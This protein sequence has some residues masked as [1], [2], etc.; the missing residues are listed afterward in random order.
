[1]TITGHRGSIHTAAFNHDGTRLVTT[2]ADST[3]KVWDA[4]TGEELF[5][6]TGHTDWV[7]DAKFNHDG[8]RIVTVSGDGTAK[9]WDTV[10]RDSCD[11]VALLVT[12]SELTETL[13]GVEPIACTNLRP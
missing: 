13:G 7:T 11:V 12:T 4:V 2:G 10:D 5:A 6:I 8:T 3:A 1:M 9:V